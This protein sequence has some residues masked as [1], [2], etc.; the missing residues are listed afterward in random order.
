MGSRWGQVVDVKQDALELTKAKKI[1]SLTASD[2]FGWKN[3]LN[4]IDLYQ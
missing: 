4:F 3:A 1:D 2:R